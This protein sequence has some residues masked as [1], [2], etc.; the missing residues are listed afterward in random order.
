MVRVCRPL[1]SILCIALTVLFL[2]GGQA[3]SAAALHLRG[4]PVA[5]H[6]VL[7]EVHVPPLSGVH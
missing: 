4:V 1:P 6:P 3:A 5:V 7:Q 2:G